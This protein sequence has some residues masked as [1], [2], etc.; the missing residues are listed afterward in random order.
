MDITTFNNIAIVNVY[1]NKH[2]T[3]LLLT[4][5]IKLWFDVTVGIFS[6]INAIQLPM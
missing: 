6:C 4:L 5:Y 2:L 3:V 1:K